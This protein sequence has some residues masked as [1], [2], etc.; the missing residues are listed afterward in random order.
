MEQEN[1]QRY[2]EYV[3]YTTVVIYCLMGYA[4][5]LWYSPNTKINLTFLYRHQGKF[6][7]SK[8]VI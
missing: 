7:D 3:I 8:G 1:I 4:Y 5:I 2:H 6:K